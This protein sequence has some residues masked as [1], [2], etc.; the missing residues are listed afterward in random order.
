MLFTINMRKNTKP[1]ITKVKKFNDLNLVYVKITDKTQSEPTEYFYEMS[2]GLT[3]AQL[4]QELVELDEYKGMELSINT[5]SI[6]G[7]MIAW[8]SINNL[9][10]PETFTYRTARV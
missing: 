3:V 9:V 7:G 1:Y 4:F 6:E 2:Y 5:V 8:P 10:A